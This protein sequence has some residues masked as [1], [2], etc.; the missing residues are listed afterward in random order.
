MKTGVFKAFCPL[1]IG[2]IVIIAL[3]DP[4]KTINPAEPQEAT[5]IPK[6]TMLVFNPDTLPFGFEIKTVTDIATLHYLKSGET[7]F[8]YE[9][10]SCKSYKPLKVKYP[11]KEHGPASVL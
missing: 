10:D 7:Q 11:D 5:W 2:D 1:E 3:P 8:M 6:N 4:V 9:L